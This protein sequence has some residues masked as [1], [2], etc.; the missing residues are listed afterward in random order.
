MYGTREK[1]Y[2]P[3]GERCQNGRVKARALLAAGLTVGFYGLALLIA[4]GLLAVAWLLWVNGEHV[5]RLTFFCVVGAGLI[6]WSILPRRERFRPPGPRLDDGTHQRLIGQVKE[7]SAKVGQPMPDEVY[8]VSDVNAG[9]RQRSG[10]MGFGGKRVMVLGLPLMQV[11]TV[12]EMRAV[13]AHE[14][15]H[16]Y[17][18]DTRLAPW[19][20][21]TREAIGRTIGN[22]A[23][24]S[25]VLHLPFL[26]Y[27]RMF[28]RVTQAMSRQQEYAADA[29]AARTMGARALIS[30]L[31]RTFGAALAYDGYW[32]EDLVPTLNAGFRPPLADGFT[33]FLRQ[34][35]VV[36]AIDRATQEEMKTPR[37]HPYDSH[38]SLPDRLRALQALPPGPDPSDDPPA[39]TLLENEAA[40]EPLLIARLLK[41][42]APPLQPLSWEDVGSRVQLP[43]WQERARRES[44]VLAG[45]TIAEIPE[46]VP[47]AT[48]DAPSRRERLLTLG[49]GLAVAL[50]K[51]GWTVE[52]LPGTTPTM[53]RN[54]D[55]VE[56]FTLVQELAQEKLQPAEWIERS[57]ALGI[58]GIQLG[59]E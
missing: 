31:R 58:S 11:L 1:S 8:L 43:F 18:G 54:A 30:G 47:P 24:Q 26:L 15:G 6:L 13:L 5:N 3:N 37:V 21:K 10:F 57:T 28:M 42:G 52:S 50:V 36:A 38:P 59:V 32:R 22:L 4:L 34:P 17:G 55:A 39:V 16:Y 29:L 56:P 9:V 27:G 53:R 14:F 44:Q 51:A 20:Y 25:S 2:T 41:P 12:S 48:W 35:N 40:V 46:M 49:A 7:I 45:H 23:R 19:I 33:Q